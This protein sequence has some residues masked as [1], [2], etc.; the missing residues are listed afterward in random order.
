MLSPF[1]CQGQPREGVPVTEKTYLFRVPYYGI[2][3]GSL[4]KVGLF[5][6]K[7]GF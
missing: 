2:Y 7:E 3:I 5:G 4:Q 1:T 6:Y